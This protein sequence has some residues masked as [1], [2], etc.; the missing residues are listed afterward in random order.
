MP[1]LNPINRFY[2]LRINCGR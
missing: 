2:W 1:K